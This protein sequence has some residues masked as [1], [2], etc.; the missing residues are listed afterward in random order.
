MRDIGSVGVEGWKLFVCSVVD[1]GSV[2]SVVNRREVAQILCDIGDVGSEIGDIGVVGREIGDVGVVG[3]EICGSEGI[4]CVIG[5]C[6]IEGVGGIEG[7]RRTVGVDRCGSFNS[8][9]VFGGGSVR[10]HRA[11][12][13]K[14]DFDFVVCLVIH[15][16][17][18]W[19]IGVVVEK[20]GCIVWEVGVISCRGRFAGVRRCFVDG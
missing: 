20:I 18:K 17:V 12:L 19:G 16:V 11:V 13:S 1:G 7:V 14:D 6:V 2:G 5:V 4:W 3:R 10:E 8:G 9:V 15:V